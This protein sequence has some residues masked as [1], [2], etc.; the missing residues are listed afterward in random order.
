[1]SLGE[2]I[3]A[4]VGDG[5]YYLVVAGEG[6]A[7]DLG[8]YAISGTVITSPDYVARPT[9]LTAAQAGSDVDLSWTCTATN[10]TGFAIERS[11]DGGA[12]C[13]Q[14]GT[15]NANDTGYNDTTTQYG[16]S[17]K[18]R[19]KATGDAQDSS[20]TAVLTANVVPNRPTNFT[21]TSVSATEIDLAWDD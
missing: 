13:N 16:H 20:Y 5:T 9:N 4:S 12:T 3:N 14:V 2:T 1:S 19:V 15:A 18:Y 21:A 17:Y 11:D 8:E 10:E 7:G 6:N